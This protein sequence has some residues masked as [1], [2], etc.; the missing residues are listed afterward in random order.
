MRS[1]LNPAASPQTLLEQEG[2]NIMRE[3]DGSQMSP[4]KKRFLQKK[5][6]KTIRVARKRAKQ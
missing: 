5:I 2:R 1:N 4:L 6:N 3:I